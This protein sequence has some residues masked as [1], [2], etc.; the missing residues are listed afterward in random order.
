M[1]NNTLVEL[2]V[3][4][5]LLDVLEGDFQ[6]GLDV[7]TP[8]F[9]LAFEQVPSQRTGRCETNGAFLPSVPSFLVPSV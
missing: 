1:K 4:G 6:L 9:Q 8:E 7:K 3:I 2:C 5:G